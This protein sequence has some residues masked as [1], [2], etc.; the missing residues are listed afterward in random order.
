[1][2]NPKDC[3]EEEVAIQ[4][5]VADFYEDIR[6]KRFYSRIYHEWWVR[7]MVSYVSRGGVF[8]DNGCGNGL[9][10]GLLRRNNMFGLDISWNM[11]NKAKSHN[12]RVVMGD[13][14][15]LPFGSAHFDVVLCRGLLH[16]LYD[17]LQGV[18]EIHRVLKP[19]GEL[20]SVDTNESII[21]KIPRSL[22]RTGVHFSRHHKNFDRGEYVK[23]IKS[24]LRIERLVFFGYIAYPLLGFPDVVDVFKLLPLKKRLCGMLIGIDEF[25]SRIPLIKTLGW[26]IL[27]KAR[28]VDTGVS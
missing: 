7:K 5:K 24:K 1:M 8:L 9:V 20:V 17:P 3:I 14:H 19:C 22:A 11:V 27:I 15:H 13:S 2:I 21:S 25:L 10:F 28:K 26:A 4:N 12:P 6:Y 23:L 18:S 16:H